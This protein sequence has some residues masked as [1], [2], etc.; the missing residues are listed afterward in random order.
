MSTVFVGYHADF[1]YYMY[2]PRCISAGS[3]D[4]GVYIL[5]TGW[6]SR[7]YC[8]SRLGTHCAEPVPVV[9]YPVLG[10]SGVVLVLG[11]VYAPNMQ[12]MDRKF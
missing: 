9:P 10:A 6:S 3:H 11:S 7:K 8:L 5:R 4:N 12:V 1:L 2:Y